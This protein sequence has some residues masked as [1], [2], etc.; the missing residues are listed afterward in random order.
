MDGS[1][2]FAQLNL[3]LL[4]GSGDPTN[5]NGVDRWMLHKK[6]QLQDCVDG[7]VYLSTFCE[8]RPSSCQF[9]CF[10]LETE[11]LDYLH[12]VT[13]IFSIHTSWCSLLHWYAIR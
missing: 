9:M 5:D 8:V 6:F 1:V 2:W 11:E 7:Y 10:C 12:I 3:R 13:L 4:F